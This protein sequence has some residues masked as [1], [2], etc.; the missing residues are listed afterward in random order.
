MREKWRR[1]AVFMEWVDGKS[2]TQPFGVSSRE[3]GPFAAQLGL[4]D[5]S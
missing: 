2:W 5:V 3:P 4:G 1:V